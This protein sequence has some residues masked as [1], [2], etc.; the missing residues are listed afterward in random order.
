MLFL[1][2]ETIMAT[3]SIHVGSNP[4]S[5]RSIFARYGKGLFSSI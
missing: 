4:Y 3:W 1:Y 5:S 2:V